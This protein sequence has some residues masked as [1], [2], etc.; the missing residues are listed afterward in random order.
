MIWAVALSA[1]ALVASGAYLALSRDALRAVVGVS[2]IGAGANLVVLSAGRL[3]AVMP[4]FVPEGASRL[5]DGAANPLPQALVLT[6]IVIGFSL[7][8]F[9]LALVMTIRQRVGDTDSTGLRAAEPPAGAD[10]LPAFP[11]DER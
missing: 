3:D 7:T 9:A 2:L 8:C 4:A 10:G 5:A 1:G 11:D 6:A